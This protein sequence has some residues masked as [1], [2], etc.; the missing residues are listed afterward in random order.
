MDAATRRREMISL[1]LIEVVII[2]LFGYYVR[3]DPAAEAP[4]PDK[5]KKGEDG[6]PVE[7]PSEYP[8]L[9][10][11]MPSVNVEAQGLH[12]KI[13]SIL[14]GIIVDIQVKT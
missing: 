13:S 2:I 5:N 1:L 3:Y 9:H 10:Q 8:P 4:C 6:R 7:N 12:Y 14:N 11:V